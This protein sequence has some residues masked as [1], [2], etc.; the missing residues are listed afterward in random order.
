[1][2]ENF[3]S[4]ASTTWMFTSGQSDVMHATLNGYR[5][6]LKNSITGGTTVNC[7][8]VSIDD[9][10]SN[11]ISIYPNPNSGTLFVS[12]AEKINSIAITNMLGKSVYFT[13]K[14][15]ANSLDLGGLQNGVYF[16]NINTNKGTYITKIILAK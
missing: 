5:T 3:M 10:L 13:T 14:F 6:N 4:Y 16:I 2:D 9:K 1:M 7:G 11:D 12:N 8:S 15:N